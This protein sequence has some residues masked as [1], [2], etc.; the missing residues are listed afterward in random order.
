MSYDSLLTQNRSEHEN[1]NLL[2]TSTHQN[3]LS[4]RPGLWPSETFAET[5]GFGSV[6]VNVPIAQK[7]QKESPER[8]RDGY[9]KFRALVEYPLSVK[10]GAKQWRKSYLDGLIPNPDGKIGSHKSRKRIWFKVLNQVW[11]TE[12]SKWSD[13]DILPIPSLPTVYK[14]SIIDH[15]ARTDPDPASKLPGDTECGV[16]RFESHEQ[17]SDADAGVGNDAG[18]ESDSEFSGSCMPDEFNGSCMP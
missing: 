8:S 3:I 16:A 7:D 2:T 11:N 18:G 14:W 1:Q 13:G 9:G 10:R 5:S 17:I 12:F 6:V 4:G 15:S